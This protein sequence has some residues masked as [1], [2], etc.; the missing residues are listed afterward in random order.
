ML[1]VILFAHDSLHGFLVGVE[2][3]VEVA[4]IFQCVARLGNF[5]FKLGD[6]FFLPDGADQGIF[7]DKQ[8]KYGYRDCSQKCERQIASTPFH[9]IVHC[10]SVV[11]LRG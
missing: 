10:V 7:V 9:E 11:F 2:R 3:M 6:A 8:N 5:S 1:H 4:V